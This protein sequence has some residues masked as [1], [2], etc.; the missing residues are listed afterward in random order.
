MSSLGHH[1]KPIGM[2]REEKKTISL[3]EGQEQEL[4]PELVENTSTKKPHSQAR[5]SLP[6]LGLRPNRGPFPL[7][8]T[9]LISTKQQ[10]TSN[11]EIL[12][13]RVAKAQRHS[14]HS[15]KRRPKAENE[16]DIEKNSLTVH[17]KPHWSPRQKEKWVSLYTLIKI[18]S[19]TLNQ[20]TKVDK[21][22]TISTYDYFTTEKHIQRAEKE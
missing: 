18:S 15:I 21:S 11:S 3:A 13:K 7:P 5:D 16:R 8:P 20:V 14:W 1:W 9:N 4:S 17:D 10:I 12:W 2:R 6:Y 19:H 22:S